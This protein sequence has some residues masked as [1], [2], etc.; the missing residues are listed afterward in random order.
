MCV[1]LR[2]S[3]GIYNGRMETNGVFLLQDSFTLPY[4]SELIW[5]NPKPKG[6]KKQRFG[7]YSGLWISCQ[8]FG[9]DVFFGFFWFRQRADTCPYCHIVA[10]SWDNRSNPNCRQFTSFKHPKWF[11]L[12]PKGAMDTKNNNTTSENY[13]KK[14]CAHNTPSEPNL[15]WR[16]MFHVNDVPTIRSMLFGDFQ[17]AFDSQRVCLV[18]YTISDIR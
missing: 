9:F 2:K 15:V 11:I 7:N 4:L 17:A 18:F 16:I 8:T 6:K 5:I 14:K 12:L 3:G 13:L 1:C 10:K